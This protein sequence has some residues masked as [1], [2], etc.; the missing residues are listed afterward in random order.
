MKSYKAIIPLLFFFLILCI[1]AFV[2][3]IDDGSDAFQH[4]L[5]SLTYLSTFNF[6]AITLSVWDKPMP[7]FLYGVSGLVGGIYGA[8]LLSI[9]L[10]LTT[11]F[12]TLSLVRRRIEGAQDI[13]GSAVILFILILPVF[14]QSFLTMTELIAGF[15]LAW[16]LYLYF[17]KSRPLLASLVAG[18]LPLARIESSLFLIPILSVFIILE[19][20]ERYPHWLHRVAGMTILSG[21]PCLLWFSACLLYSGDFFYIAYNGYTFFRPFEFEKYAVHNA[22]TAL[23]SILLPPMLFLALVGI[24]Q[25]SRNWF[26]TS[27]NRESAL[28]LLCLL[29]AITFFVFTLMFIA[30]P[31]GEPNWE[32]LIP[33][34]NGRAYNI[35]APVITI[36]I[37]LGVV[38]LRQ[39]GL[40]VEGYMKPGDAVRYLIAVWLI[41]LALIYVCMKQFSINDSAFS[42]Q[43]G[44]YLSIYFATLILSL[45]VIRFKQLRLQ[46]WHATGLLIVLSFIAILPRFY[47]P[48]RFNDPNLILQSELTDFVSERFGNEPTLLLQNFAPSIEYFIGKPLVRANWQWP[49]RFIEEAVRFN[50]T[51][52]VMIRT[53]GQEQTPLPV[54]DENLLEFLKK[55]HEVRRSNIVSPYGWILYQLN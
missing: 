20:H 16:S 27:W 12:M 9:F 41:G 52:L 54:Y 31:P 35:V 26:S 23:P 43:T 44:L 22:I 38:K 5:Q 51:V 1:T 24:F 4:Y 17:V 42:R 50:G 3:T 6:K 53:E 2:Y 40:D 46:I 48:T 47:E 25:V 34:I 10:C 37:C 28:L 30:Y 39:L 32:R 45:G 15:F 11:A 14:L 18:F 21:I 8:R 29:I 13:P 33:V 19:V 55:F 7:I 36:F 49:N